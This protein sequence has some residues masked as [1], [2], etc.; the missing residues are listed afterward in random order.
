[1]MPY[2]IRIGSIALVIVTVG[3]LGYMT[4]EAYRPRSWMGQFANTLTPF[5]GDRKRKQSGLELTKYEQILSEGTST[6]VTA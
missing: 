4:Y 6:Q 1:M 2:T 5:R 3:L